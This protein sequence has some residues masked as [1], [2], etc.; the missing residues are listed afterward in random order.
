MNAADVMVTNVITVGPDACLQDV[1]HLFLTNR[2]SA[3]PVVGSDGKILGI[4]SE[5]DLMRRAEAGTGRRRS[6]WLSL[7]TG[8]DVLA[9]EYIKEH[10][11]KVADVMTCEVITAAPE[12]SLRD[13]ASILEKNSIKRV[14]IVKDGKIV[15]IVSRANLL[16]ALASLRKQIEGGA[17]DDGRIR[18]SI[19]ER[20]KAEPWSRPS[21]INVIVQDGTVELW[22]IVDSS[23]ERKAV[24]VAAEV[25]PGVCAV[26]DNLIIRPAELGIIGR[27]QS[28]TFPSPVAPRSSS[29]PDPAD[30][31]LKASTG[32]IAHWWRGERRGARA[33]SARRCR[34]DRRCPRA[35]R[36]RHAGTGEPLP[37]W[38]PARW[39]RWLTTSQTNELRAEFEGTS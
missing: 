7:L 10:S 33:Q 34:M 25:T 13:I 2:I 27:Y 14:P 19:V 12:T 21:L 31:P 38:T 32:Q 11:R 20:L 24:R 26:N 28:S 36:C 1:A 29:M 30:S 37:I 39:P 9:A 5:G 3:V 6:W 16:Q 15:G 8:R 18:E 17:P 22:G 4:V 35:A 23:V